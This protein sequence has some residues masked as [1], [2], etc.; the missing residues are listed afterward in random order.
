MLFAQF[1]R[2]DSLASSLCFRWAAWRG[3]SAPNSSP[4]TTKGESCERMAGNTASLRARGQLSVR[5]SQAPADPRGCG[6]SSWSLCLGR[7]LI[8]ILAAIPSSRSLLGQSN[9]LA[10]RA[11]DLHIGA[12]RFGYKPLSLT[13]LTNVVMQPL[14]PYKST[15]EVSWLTFWHLGG[16]QKRGF[17]RREPGMRR[18]PGR[19]REQGC[20]WPREPSQ[21]PV[22]LKL[23][24]K[25]CK[26]SSLPAYHKL[27]EVCIT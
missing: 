13:K 4:G 15:V 25:V 24:G 18:M 5:I 14:R 9:A 8:T 21:R 20:S 22:R 1:T 7:M 16:L 19:A 26:H 2:V 11:E 17:V 12:V 10:N 3:T 6:R 23:P 27:K